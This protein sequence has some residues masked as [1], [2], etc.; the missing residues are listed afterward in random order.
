MDAPKDHPQHGLLRSGHPTACKSS[1]GR[2]PTPWFVIL[3][4]LPVILMLEVR[5]MYGAW[6]FRFME[7][8]HN[9]TSFTK[10]NWLLWINLNSQ[11]KFKFHGFT[12]G[13]L[14]LL[15][16]PERT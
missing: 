4:S 16:S 11:N 1:L 5:E 10:V 14:N 7:M 13:V 3:T 2:S 9:G 6:G 15:Q 12:L 8:V